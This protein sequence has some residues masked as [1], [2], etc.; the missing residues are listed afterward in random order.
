MDLNALLETVPDHVRDLKLN[1]TGLLA[2]P[3]LTD[4]QRYGSALTAA[5]VS[6]NARLTRAILAEATTHLSAEAINA[7]KIAASIMG[8]NNVYY[9]FRHVVS[10]KQYETMPTKL[11]MQ[12]LARPGIEKANFELYCLVASAINGCSACSDS[13]EKVVRQAGLSLEAVQTGVRIASVV[14]GLA[15]AL[16]IE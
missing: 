2:D 3:T 5:Y 1:L 7:A 8:M 9:R 13:H 6:R 14:H 4:E 10:E 11:R 15:V 12:S 16:E